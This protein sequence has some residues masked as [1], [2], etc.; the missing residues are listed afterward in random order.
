[1]SA[2]KEKVAVFFNIDIYVGALLHRAT[3]FHYDKKCCLRRRLWQTNILSRKP[4]FPGCKTVLWQ[5]ETA[6]NGRILKMEMTFRTMFLL[7]N[8]L[9]VATA[10][11]VLFFFTPVAKVKKTVL[12]DVISRLFATGLVKGCYY[13][14][15]ESIL[16]HFAVL[17]IYV[18]PSFGF[19]RSTN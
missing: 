9:V 5:G 18:T 19:N 8:S 13:R 4:N 16:A 3:E 2:K 17:W 1:M 10:K 14:N 6:H 12:K 7:L 15:K 11:K